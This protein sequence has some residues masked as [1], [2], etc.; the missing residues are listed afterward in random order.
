MLTARNWPIS[1]KTAF[2]LVH[3]NG[4]GPRD[5]IARGVGDSLCSPTGNCS[6]WVLEPVDHGYRVILNGDAQTISVLPTSTNRWH[7]IVLTMHGSATHSGMTLYKFDGHRYRESGCYEAS[8]LATD[9]N[10]K[11]EDLEEARITPCG[12]K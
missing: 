1:Q 2:S 8:F 12:S 6:V 10:G 7:D 4:S 9:E 5:V 11:V 3:L